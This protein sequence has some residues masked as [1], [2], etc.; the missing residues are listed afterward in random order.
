M[1]AAVLRDTPA[2]A[3]VKGNPGEVMKITSDRLER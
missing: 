2:L 3:V 1:A